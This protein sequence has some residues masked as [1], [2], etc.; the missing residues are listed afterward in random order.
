MALVPKLLRFA[1]VSL[2]NFHIDESHGLSHCMNVLHHSHNILQSELKKDPNLEAH[3]NIIY[4]S[5]ILHDICDSK[6]TDPTQGLQYI[7]KF[8][9]TETMLTPTEID[10]SCQIMN[11]MSYSKVRRVGYPDLGNYQMAYHIV[12]EADLLSAYDFDRSILYNIHNTGHGKFL[13]SMDNALVLFRDRV[14][15]HNE[16]DLFMTEYSKKL[17]KKLEI[18]AYK[19]IQDWE[20]I[21]QSR[22][23]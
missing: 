21:L 22:L 15:L 2:Q 6:Y 9:Q 5:S 17:S 19:R 4:T 11:T 7:T 8:L 14:F 23:F 1:V 3:R 12:R 18:G 13:D 10:M 16:H 20:A